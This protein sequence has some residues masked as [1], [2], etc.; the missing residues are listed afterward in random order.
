MRNILVRSVNAGVGDP[1]VTARALQ[2]V[3][4]VRMQIVARSLGS[5]GNEIPYGVEVS[6]NAGIVATTNREDGFL[7]DGNTPPVVI[8]KA[9]E[10]GKQGNDIS[11][12]AQGTEVPQDDP[13]TPDT[14]ERT[15]ATVLLTLSARG[16]HLC[17]GNEPYSPIT[18]ENPLVPGE[19]II[20]FGTGLGLTDNQEAVATGMPT[21]A[22]TVANV[23]LVSD[24]FVSS[25][26]GGRTAQVEF[27]GLMEGSV[28]VYQV[29]LRTNTDL[30]DN[31]STPL[32]IAQGLFISNVISLPVKNLVPRPPASF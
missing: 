3:G 14:N 25:Q 28:G 19:L 31:P 22:G 18:P 23:P 1:E 8:L 7:E 27:V 4:S 32:W 13:A 15:E 26:F 10:A 30:N 11:Y 12:A 24:D 6:P 2:V 17:C 9:R 5:D 29:N 21:P 16:S 20:V